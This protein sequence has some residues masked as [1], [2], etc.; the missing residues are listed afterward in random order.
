MDRS[1]AASRTLVTFAM[2]VAVACARPPRAP[3]TPPPRPISTDG[4]VEV[5]FVE[6][7]YT[8]LQA[9]IDDEAR[10]A[11]AVGRYARARSLFRRLLQLDPDDTRALREAGRVAQALGDYRAAVDAFARIAH[12]DPNRPD[13]ERH[14]LRGEALL[15]L[16]RRAE[17]EREWSASEAELGAVPVD[18]RTLMWR[19]RIA[20]LR[21]QPAQ[22]L[23]LYRAVRTTDR[24]DP[25][26][27]EIAL[28]EI[29]AKILGGDWPQAMA[30][31][32]AL[33]REAPDQ[34]RVRALLA[35]GHEVRGDDDAALALRAAVADE[36]PD[37]PRKTVEYAR[38]LER[39]HADRAALAEYRE[40]RALGVPDV[41]PAI[42][43]LRHRLDPEV[44]GGVSFGGDASGS[45]AG[46]RAG[47]TV[48]IDGQLRVALAV[49]R[50]TSSGGLAG[51]E[52][53]AATAAL[54]AL[55]TSRRGAV[56]G[57]AITGR[58]RTAARGLG[59]SALVTTDPRRQVQLQ[60]RA[61]YGQAWRESSSTIREGGVIDGA[62]GSAY[63][64]GWARRA[65]FSAS[66]QQRRLTL[67]PLPGMDEVAAMQV[68][69][70]LGVDYTVTLDRAAVMRGEI[71]DGE[72]LT[73]RGLAS[74]TVVSLRHYEMV[75]EAPFGARLVLVE[76]SQTDEASAVV[77]RVVGGGAVGV[78]L[79]GG[80]GYDWRRGIGLYRLGASLMLSATAGSRVTADYDVGSESGTGLVGRRHAG[81]VVLHVDL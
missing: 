59:A 72:M 51:H 28:L 30:R 69:G 37:H 56:Y 78:E 24:H 2:T 50:D 6:P 74:A 22:A 47:A 80:A 14:F 67:A 54:W 53:H 42:A 38:A 34:P 21:G 57:L 55:A 58:D 68:V 63:V 70:A 52:D 26:Y 19:A 45:I 16:G 17:A 15:A 75:S 5:A 35:W 49:A 31:L 77:R 4:D 66:V 33:D 3:T 25:A 8:P 11:M 76:R 48:P 27:L 61:D 46:L 71:L 64:S 43:R 12:L 41:D 79:R 65:L 44:A 23:G 13:P 1:F 36:W 32:R 40:A 10:A 20:A 81:S 73:P 62:I 29:E 18:R 9:L 39:V 7:R 60:L